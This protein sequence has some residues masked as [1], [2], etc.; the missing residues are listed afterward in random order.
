MMEIWQVL[1]IIVGIIGMFIL[2]SLTYRFS[3]FQQFPEKE[4]IEGEKGYVI[5]ILSRFIYRCWERFKGKGESVICA[6]LTIKSNEDINS[7]DVLTNLNQ[8]RIDKS[9]VEADDLGSSG[10]VIIRYENKKIYVE[11]VKYERISS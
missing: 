9:A 10:E 3:E 7:S 6:Y 8:L 2:I 1:L 4:K 5:D 11:K